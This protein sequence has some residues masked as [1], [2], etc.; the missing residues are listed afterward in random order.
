MSAN[1]YQKVRVNTP[2]T[3]K[4][5]NLSTVINDCTP[6]KKRWILSM[7]GGGSRGVASLQ[8]LKRLEEWRGRSVIDEFD[9]FVCVSAGALCILAIVSGNSSATKVRKEVF[10]VQNLRTILD[11]NLKNCMLPLAII[12]GTKYNGK[13]KTKV[14]NTV[15]PNIQMSDL[16]KPVWVP[17]WNLSRGEECVFGPDCDTLIRQVADATSAAP[18][19]FPPVKIGYDWYIDGGIPSNNPCLVGLEAAKLTWP[20]DDI[21]ILSVGTGAANVTM[22][23]NKMGNCG[24]VAWMANGLLDLVMSAP[25]K[26]VTDITTALMPPGHFLR[27]DSEVHADLAPLDWNLISKVFNFRGTYA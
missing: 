13:G 23:G 4:K 24:A 25:C 16:R 21:R 3:I 5:L 20:D 9:G 11:C 19:Y 26:A 7:D 2:S 14:I 18:V 8:F 17:T 6:R 15:L 12:P 22:D 1:R 10:S 27:I